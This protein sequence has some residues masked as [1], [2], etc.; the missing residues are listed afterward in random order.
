MNITVIAG[1]NRTGARSLRLA[2]RVA[3]LHEAAGATTTVLDLAALPVEI[4]SPDA[5]AHKPAALQPFFDAVLSADGL[6]VVSPEY[7]GGMPGILKLF[8]DMLPFPE[9]FEHRPVCFL[10]LSAGRWG[11]LRPVEQLQAVFGYRN[12]FVFPDRVFVPGV[13]EGLDAEG[14][15][16]DPFVAGLIT[17]QAQGF[18]NFCAAVAPLR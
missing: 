2:R 8:I 15:P 4:A 13:A 14:W 1:T 5:Y 11:A 16:T 3:A 9:S 17:S 10:G 7:N 6:V 12:A 18:R